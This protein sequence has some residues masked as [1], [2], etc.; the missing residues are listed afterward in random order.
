MLLLLLLPLL[1]GTHPHPTNSQTPSPSL[2]GTNVLIT[3]G[4]D[5]SLSNNY[6]FLPVTS[7]DGRFTAFYSW[8]SNLVP[9]DTNGVGDV[10]VYDRQLAEIRR[11]SVASD[12]TQANAG[13]GDYW[14]V[15][16]SGNG[17]FVTFT[18]KATNLVA[19]D[20][21]GHYDTFV[22]DLLTDET[23][24]VSVAS[25]GTQANSYSDLPSISTDG[26]YVAFNSSATNLVAGVTGSQIYVHDRETGQTELV[27]IGNDGNPVYSSKEQ[28]I[29]GDGRFVTF[30]CAGTN[31]VPGDTTF[32]NGICVRD[33][34]AGYNEFVSISSSGVPGN[35][36]SHYPSLSATGR[37]VVF[38]SEATNLVVH[39]TNNAS[40]VFLHDRLTN[41]TEL[42][43]VSSS[44]VQADDDTYYRPFVS[45]NGQFVVFHSSGAGLV[46]DDINGSSDVFLRDRWNGITERISTASNGTEGDLDSYSSY[47]TPDGRFIVYESEATNLVPGDTNGV[48]DIFLRDRFP[49]SS[50]TI[51]GQI[52]AYDNGVGIPAEGVTVQDNQGHSTISDATGTYTL[53]LAQGG[54]Y[55]VTPT[56]PSLTFSPPFRDVVVEIGAT[57]IDF[58]AFSPH[59]DA[60]EDGLLNS[61][62]IEGYDNNNDDIIDVDLPAFGANPLHKDIFVEVDYM[63]EH[64]QCSSNP[65]TSVGHTHRPDDT[66]IQIVVDSLAN[67]PVPNPDNQTGIT[68]HVDYGQPGALAGNTSKS[69]RIPHRDRIQDQGTWD[70]SALNQLRNTYFS[71]ERRNIFH[72]AWFAHFLGGGY[73]PGVSGISTNKGAADCDTQFRQGASTFV[74][75]LGAWTD[76]TGTIN[77]QAG[78]FMHE[79]G[80][81]LGLCHGGSQPDTN[82]KPNYLSTMNYTFQTKGLIVFG[83]EGNFDYS[84]SAF[85]PLNEPQLD[86][87]VGLNVNS[88]FSHYGT[89]YFCR[90]VS[91]FD[92][93]FV[94]YV[95]SPIDWDCDGSMENTVS[96]NI[97]D[98]HPLVSD[99][100]FN[101]L[102]GFSDW[103]NLSFSGRGTF[104]KLNSAMNTFPT[105]ELTVDVA[106]SILSPYEV[107]LEGGAEFVVSPG[108]TTTQNITITNSGTITSTVIVNTSSTQ[109][110]FDYS[111]IPS[112]L[113]MAP[114]ESQTFLI[115]I[116]TP[117]SNSNVTTATLSL[118]A[119]PDESSKMGDELTVAVHVGPLAWFA[120]DVITGT[121]P[122]TVSFTDLSV[123]DVTS[124]SWDFGDGQTNNLQNPTHIYTEGGHYT[125]TLTVSGPAG[126]NTSIREQLI[127]VAPPEKLRLYI[128]MIS[129]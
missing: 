80:H 18:S 64:P 13:P 82:F 8:A 111:E 34:I 47:I 36:T 72:Y 21:N 93:T 35:G 119:M 9:G 27:S 117:L 31:V 128:P 32:A 59:E 48:R 41:Q 77:E 115:T 61:W 42:I 5:G 11:V 15:A 63:A 39:D 69:D 55:K 65:C 100:T 25:D 126:N 51:S 74:V 107:R 78:T 49:S 58:N 23:E 14:E 118:T 103:Q 70:E 122:L 67:A 44:G 45:L 16:I 66:A 22:H 116:T 102:T 62:E 71:P 120:Y 1:L 68:L 89:R 19:G 20:T 79:L 53:T 81:N 2:F 94:N 91:P 73:D 10:F 114:A 24:R 106:R 121:A 40:D 28:Y 109:P 37:F 104:P 29:S 125:V 87:T 97:N 57:S 85:P 83:Q 92:G 96:A 105:D 84:R 108:I 26:R 54:T 4:Y 30:V 17:R 113:T 112:S 7:D 56:D 99:P 127:T 75:S 60:D 12:G 38:Y 33:R 6:S 76:N 123:G 110:W 101:T 129:K 52:L 3:R 86:E 98:G 50:I 90:G 95:N 124:W 46:P 88:D 43:S